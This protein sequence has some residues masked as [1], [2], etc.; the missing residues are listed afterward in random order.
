MN[1]S[2]G[3][4]E[5]LKSGAVRE[6][7]RWLWTLISSTGAWKQINVNC[8]INAHFCTIIE[9]TTGYTLVGSLI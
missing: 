5:N 6:S 1:V 7:G 9:R 8:A 2:S 4:G 3:K